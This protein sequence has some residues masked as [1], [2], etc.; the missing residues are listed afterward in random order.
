[1][2][3]ARLGR[4]A[5][6]GA[7]VGRADLRHELLGRVAVVTEAAAELAGHA[8]AVASPVHALMGEGRIVGRRVVERADRRHLHIVGRRRVERPI[9]AIA[10]PHPDTGEEFVSLGDPFG[11]DD[12]G[13]RRRKPLRAKSVDLLDVEH[14][15]GF[16]IADRVFFGL[17]FAVLALFHK[18]V[19][20]N[21]LSALLALADGRAEGER[22][23]EGHPSRLA[24]ALGR[25]GAPKDQ[26][27][28]A[29]IGLAG[30][31]AR[32]V[33][34]AAGGASA[35]PGARPRPHASFEL[36]HDRVG[37]GLIHVL[38]VGH[39]QTSRRMLAHCSRRTSSRAH[40]S[41]S[42]CLPTA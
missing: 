28:D 29:P 8:A 31:P 20:E 37:D 26:D 32:K 25:G 38:T 6:E 14:G 13:D 34:T 1:M 2:V 10:H 36:G 24:V 42:R 33:D 5:E 27:I 3:G 22:L 15:V 30:D 11:T 41:A 19:R 23:F 18:L 12:R 35:R 4:Q 39:D 40:S 16:Q 21:H 7:D 17:A 9:A